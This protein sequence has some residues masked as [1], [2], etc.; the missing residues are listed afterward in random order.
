MQYDNNFLGKNGFIW[1]NGVVEDRNDPQKVGR[2]RVRCLGYHTEVKSELPTADLPWASCVL[3]VTSSGISGLG[4]HPFIVEGSWVFGYFRDGNDCQEPVILGTL[5]GKPIENGKP[6][7]GF[8]DPNVRTDDSG[9]SVY[10]REINE[11]DINRLAV[12]DVNLVAASLASRRLARRITMATADFDATSGADGSTIAASDGTTWNQPVIPY[13]AVYPYNHVYESES[14]HVLEFDDSFIIDE[15]G[16]RVNHYRVHMRHTSGTSFEW[17]NNGD[18]TALN[19]GDHYNIT[20]GN[21][22]QQIDGN[23]ELTIDGHYK[24][25]INGDGE[26]DNHYDIQVGP[27]A[28]INI[29]VDTGKIN[30]ITKQGDVNVNAGGNYNVKVGGN[31]TMTVAG[32][33]AVTVN[34]TT[35]DTTQGAVQHRGSTIDL[36]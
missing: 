35:N 9:H 34:G 18:H 25:R 27:N 4:G 33:R 24:L 5:P 21:W 1:F 22:Q 11:T 10:P 29:Q 32:N 2:L 30:L 6:S 31:Y 17:H 13:E 7:S 26:T 16:D 3:P 23:R 28:N 15:N 12:N 19:K 8:Y 36:N 20:T 14:G